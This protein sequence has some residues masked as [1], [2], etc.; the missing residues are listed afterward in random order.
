[1]KAKSAKAKGRKF[2]QQIAEGIANTHGLTHGKDEDCESRGMGQCGTDVRLSKR[3]K[4]LFPYSV[5]CKCQERLNFWDAI[6]QARTNVLEDTDWLLVVKRNRETPV[7]ILDWEVF[8]KLTEDSE[9]LREMEQAYL[10]TLSPHNMGVT[11]E[12]VLNELQRKSKTGS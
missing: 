9:Y 5:E 3:A 4:E 12:D 10:D 7:A 1:M 11:R 8:L 2:Q 6:N